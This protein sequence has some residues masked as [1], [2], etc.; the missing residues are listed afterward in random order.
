MHQYDSQ[1]R[2]SW[3]LLV[4]LIAGS[5]FSRFHPT[6]CSAGEILDYATADPEL[7]AVR[8]DSDLKESFLAVEL[9]SAGRLF[10]GGREA[11]FVYEP[12]E[13][14][15]TGYGP[16]REVYR[17]PNHTWI[18]DIAIRG[19]DVYV[20][21]VSALYVIPRA[22]FDSRPH[23]AKGRPA[24]FKAKRLIWGVPFGHVH[25]CFHGMAIGPEGEP[26]LSVW[27]QDRL[28]LVAAEIR[29]RLAGSGS[30]PDPEKP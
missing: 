10:V 27:G 18:Y 30:A 20:L 28:W 11:L 5:L 1:L 4:M 19:P 9:T 2:N 15:P 22:E 24:K 26:D 14:S 13:G 21:T 12:S 8:I 17:F 25:Q 3:L 23:R 16:R 29:R 6:T 7:K